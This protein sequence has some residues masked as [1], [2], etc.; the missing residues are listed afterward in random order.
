MEILAELGNIHRDT[1]KE[2]NDDYDDYFPIVEEILYTALHKENFAMKDPSLDH[3]AR[4]IDEVAP[5]VTGASADHGKSK[6][7]D[8]LGTSRSKCAYCPSIIEL[9]PPFLLFLPL[10]PFR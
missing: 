7:D 2:N 4:G 10:T 5:E 3:T 9:R 6:P 8:G 1:D